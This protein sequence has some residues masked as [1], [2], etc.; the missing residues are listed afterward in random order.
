MWRGAGWCVVRHAAVGRAGVI[1]HADKP[2]VAR[3]VERRGRHLEELMRRAAHCDRALVRVRV[4]VRVRGRV[5]VRVRVRLT[6]LTW[7]RVRVRVRLTELTWLSSV[8]VRVRVRLTEL[9]WLS[10][11]EATRLPKECSPSMVHAC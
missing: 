4:K 2:E 9:T 6:L 10:S 1:H 3:G 5:R 11:A 7:L 8:R